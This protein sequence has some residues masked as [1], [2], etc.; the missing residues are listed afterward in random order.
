MKTKLLR[1][2]DIAVILIILVVAATFWLYQS[3]QTDK[4]EAVISVNGETV[5]VIDLSTTDGKRTVELDTSPKVVIAIENGAVYFE[6]A[7]CDDKLCINCGKLSKKGD[8]AVCLPAKTV[9]TV[10]GTDVDVMTY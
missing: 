2:G 8:T 7:D 9:V 5:E 4:L 10:S 1:K 6:K 3:R